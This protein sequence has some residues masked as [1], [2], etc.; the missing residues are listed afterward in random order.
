MSDGPVC[1][2]GTS[3]SVESEPH[4][5]RGSTANWKNFSKAG[6]IDSKN[7]LSRTIR[8]TYIPCVVHMIKSQ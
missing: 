6:L 8:S 5:M 4:K 1:L 3:E 2:V 7:S